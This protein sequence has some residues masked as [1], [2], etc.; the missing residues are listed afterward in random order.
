M[1]RGAAIAGPTHRRR[2][3][4]T[5]LW[6]FLATLFVI[7]FAMN[8]VWEMLQMAAY[9]E[10]SQQPWQRTVL[11]CTAASIGDGAITLLAFGVGALVSPTLRARSARSTTYVL[12]A[13]I[14]AAFAIVI[15]HVALRAQEWSYNEQMPIV[16]LLGVGLYPLLQLTILVPIAYALALGLQRSRADRS[17]A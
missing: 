14:G 6:A 1:L 5:R 16:P 7:A 17:R 2:A 15:E 10:L 8:W 9:A 11:R 12:L 3:G 4:V 13:S